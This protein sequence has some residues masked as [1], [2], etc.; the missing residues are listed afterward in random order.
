[1]SFKQVG[2]S[3]FVAAVL[4]L[5][6]GCAHQLTVLNL[7]DYHASG[8]VEVP[9]TSTIGVLEGDIDPS[10][11]V[12]LDGVAAGLARSGAQVL[13]P[14]RPASDKPAD[15]V[16]RIGIKA[17]YDGSGT[18]FWLNFPGFL[19]WAPAWNGYVYKADFAVHVELFKGSDAKNAVDTFDIPVNLDIRHAEMDRTWME[20]SWFEVGIIALVTG[21]IYTK[22]DTDVT[23]LL[24]HEIERPI[25]DYIAH[26]IL[27]KFPAP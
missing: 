27:E 26:K 3:A 8:R 20:V 16:A 21:F 24:M 13:N 23:P 17:K 18:N 4:V 14:Y 6:S 12:L 1:M 7:D 22:Y 11:T 19:I 9:R 15:L 10:A 5:L 25:G 2:V